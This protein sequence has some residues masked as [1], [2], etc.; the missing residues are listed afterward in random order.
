[1]GI[2]TALHP[3]GGGAKIKIDTTPVRFDYTGAVQQYVVPKGV[4]K[5]AVDCVGARGTGNR[6]SQ[7]IAGKGGRVQCVLKVT[8]GQTLYIYVGEAG[9]LTQSKESFNGGAPGGDFNQSFSNS[10][11]GGGATDIRT[12]PATEGSWYDKSHTSW[13][14]DQSLLSRLVVAG[15]GGGTYTSN[16]QSSGGDGGGLTGANGSGLGG[17]SRQGKGGT[18]TVGGTAS[19]GGNYQP[20]NFGY[21]GPGV[22]NSQNGGVWWGCAGGGG[23]YGGGCGADYYGAGGGGGSSYTHPELCSDVVHTRGF[24]TGNGY[25][26]LTPLEK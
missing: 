4:K 5:L 9:H 21:G 7:E 8:P 22:Y 14:T 16:K 2:R 12:V 6:R 25:L 20:G 26:I 23:W 13:A 19:T 18:Q 1:M 24:N 11:N 10:A 17:D 15:A 3:L